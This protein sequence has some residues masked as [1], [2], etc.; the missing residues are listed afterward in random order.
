MAKLLILAVALLSQAPSVLSWTELRSLEGAFRV[1]FPGA[2]RHE[3]TDVPTRIGPIRMQRWFVEV[4]PDVYQLI[5]ADYPPDYVKQAGAEA[6]LDSALA[7]MRESVK[8]GSVFESVVPI[9][10][11]GYPGREHVQDVDGYMMKGRSILIGVRL[12]QVL[13]GVPSGR[14]AAALPDMDRFLGSFALIVAR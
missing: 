4:G 8:A 3:A 11:A 1:T 14:R 7:Q 9:T 10:L 13:A 2:V 6:M 5:Y 12:Y